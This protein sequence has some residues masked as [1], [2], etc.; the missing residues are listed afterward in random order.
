MRRF[1]IISSCSRK[2]IEIQG[3]SISSV[4]KKLKGLAG[5]SKIDR[6]HN[7]AVMVFMTF[8]GMS[9][10]KAINPSIFHTIAIR[11]R[12]IFF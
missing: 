7:G 2:F 4:R 10:N 8:Q 6:R 9:I 5:V 12:T 3:V 11:I 1:P